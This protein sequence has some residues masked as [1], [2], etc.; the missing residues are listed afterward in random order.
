MSKIKKKKHSQN[1]FI[2]IKE[3]LEILYKSVPEH[4]IDND[5]KVCIKDTDCPKIWDTQ[6]YKNMVASP[7]RLKNVLCEAQ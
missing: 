3:I 5:V 6:Y 2:D 7:M 1:G 4:T